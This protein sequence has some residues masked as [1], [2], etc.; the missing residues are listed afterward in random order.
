MDEQTI[1]ER[2]K[3]MVMSIS[4]DDVTDERLEELAQYL[5]SNKSAVIRDSVREKYERYQANLPRYEQDKQI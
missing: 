3:W 5:S 4:I 1:E 2:K